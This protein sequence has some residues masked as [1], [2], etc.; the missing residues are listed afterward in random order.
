MH[1]CKQKIFVCSVLVL[2]NLAVVNTGIKRI[3]LFTG[4][5]CFVQNAKYGYIHIRVNYV[6]T[7]NFTVCLRFTAQRIFIVGDYKIVRIISVLFRW[8]VYRYIV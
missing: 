2:K 5:L 4:K 6:L 8:N 7:E 1:F 3:L